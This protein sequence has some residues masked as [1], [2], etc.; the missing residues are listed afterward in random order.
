[1][2]PIVI[3]AASFMGTTSTRQYA[4]SSSGIKYSGTS[5]SSNDNG[6]IWNAEMCFGSVCK[7]CGQCHING[8]D[9]SAKVY[10]VAKHQVTYFPKFSI[11]LAEGQRLPWGTYG[12]FLTLKRGQLSYHLKDGTLKMVAPLGSV[13]L[14]DRTGKPF[15]LRMPGDPIVK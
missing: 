10:T 2:L 8:A 14:K 6:D 12:G 9:L 13:I 1:M 5:S 11:V 15:L 3:A 7:P 4:A